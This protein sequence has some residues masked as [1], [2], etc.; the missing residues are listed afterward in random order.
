MSSDFTF[1]GE[2]PAERSNAVAPLT[3]GVAIDVPDRSLNPVSHVECIATPG[4]TISG[5]I[6]LSDVGPRLLNE[7]TLSLSSTAPTVIGAL[8]HP[9]DNIVLLYGPLLPAATTTTTHFATALSTAFDIASVPSHVC[10][11]APRLMLITSAPLLTAQSIPDIILDVYPEPYL[12]RTFTL[13]RFAP[14]ATPLYVGSFE[15]TMPATCVP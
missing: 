3:C 12:F 1:P 9:G 4:A 14:Y 10:N 8:A 2:A 15:A 11:L 6:L 7:G 5:F 13:K